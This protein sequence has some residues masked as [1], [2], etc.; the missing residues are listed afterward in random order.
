MLDIAANLQAVRE[1]IAKAQENSPYAAKEVKLVAVSKTKPA[2]LI[3]EGGKSRV[4]P[5]WAKT[6]YRN[7]WKNT[8]R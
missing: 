7:S 6:K 4:L 2:E 5:I 3:N 8:I 1:A